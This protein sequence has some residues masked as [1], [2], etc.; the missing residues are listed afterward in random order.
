M[1]SQLFF[2]TSLG[3]PFKWAY[4]YGDFDNIEI[5]LVVKRRPGGFVCVIPGVIH[6]G[7]LPAMH[8]RCG[9]RRNLKR[10]RSLRL[11]FHICSRKYLYC[12]VLKAIIM[13]QKK[14]WLPELQKK[15]AKRCMFTNTI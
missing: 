1:K 12:Q 11:G 6:V 15:I 8:E 5:Y 9:I 2:F 7:T 14:G 13:S 10:L 4:A 3:F